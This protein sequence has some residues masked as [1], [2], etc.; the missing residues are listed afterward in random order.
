MKH[1]TGLRQNAFLK[2]TNEETLILNA[3]TNTKTRERERGWE[4]EREIQR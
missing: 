3:S 2:A 1:S 4:R